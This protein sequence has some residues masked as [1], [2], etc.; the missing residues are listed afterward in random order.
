MAERHSLQI[1]VEIKKIKLQVRFPCKLSFQIKIGSLLLKK[2]MHNFNLK[3]LV[4]W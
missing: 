4:N 2:T 1:T 3:T